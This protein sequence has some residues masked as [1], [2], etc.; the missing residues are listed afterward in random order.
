MSLPESALPANPSDTFET[1]AAW[2]SVDT[3]TLPGNVPLG[4]LSV[5]DSSVDADALTEGAGRPSTPTPTPEAGAYVLHRLIARG[6]FGEVWEAT[7]ASIGRIVAVKRLRAEVVNRGGSTEV[8]FRQE[9]LTA[10]QLEHPNIVPVHDLGADS[11]GRPV[12]AMKMVRGRTWA[13]QIEEDFPRLPVAE[14]LGAHLPI[15]M[16]TAQA[17]AFAHSRGVVHRDLKP[18]QVMTGEFGE[19][20][21]MDWGLAMAFGEGRQ[22]TDFARVIPGR[23]SAS[24]P[25]GTPVFMAPE[26][27]RNDASGVGPWT[28]VFLLGGIL[29]LLL[30]G[31]PP[32]DAPTSIMAMKL[33]E[34][35]AVES[36]AKRAKGRE[37]PSELERICLKALAKEPSQRHESAGALLVALRDYISGASRRRQAEELARTASQRLDEAASSYLV[38][39]EAISLAAQARALW[40]E[41]PSARGAEERGLAL[42]AEAALRKGDLGLA[43]VQSERLPET[44]ERASLAARIDSAEA[45]LRRQGA[46]RRAA[47]AAAIAML[48]LLVAGTL[49]YNT[50]LS[51][52]RDRA[53]AAR[54]SAESARESEAAARAKERLARAD[55]EQLARFM[56]GDL[57]EKLAPRDPKLELLDAAATEALSYYTGQT[58]DTLGPEELLTYAQGAYTLADLLRTQGRLDDAETAAFAAEA[59]AGAAAASPQ[60]RVDATR[61]R[62]ILSGIFLQIHFARG[63][64]DLA[65]QTAAE[66]SARLEVLRAEGVREVG[67]LNDLLASKSW[68][69]ALSRDLAPPEEVLAKWDAY[70]EVLAD[71]RDLGMPDVRYLP[72]LGALAQ[73]RARLQEDLGQIELADKTYREALEVLE[74]AY[75]AA[76]PPDRDTARFL[77]T[78]CYRYGRF[79]IRREDT[80]AA[81]PVLR[82]AHEVYL[83]LAEASPDNFEL[84]KELGVA[85]EGLVTLHD[86]L[87]EHA[88]A[89]ARL[90]EQIALL[91]RLLERSPDNL[92]W[93]RERIAASI[94]L[95]RTVSKLGDIA[96]ALAIRKDAQELLRAKIVD[97]PADPPLRELAASLANEA[98]AIALRMGRADE[99]RAAFS[100]AIEHYR[101]IPEE[102]RPLKNVFQEANLLM[103]LASG[104]EIDGDDEP[105]PALFAEARALYERVQREGPQLDPG[106]ANL[107][108]CLFAGAESNLRLGRFDAARDHSDAA[109][110]IV[111][112]AL[113]AAPDDAAQ[114]RRCGQQLVLRGRIEAAA[115]GDAAPFL[116]EGLALLEPLAEGSG[117][118]PMVLQAVAW[119]RL[120]SGDLEGAREAFGRMPAALRKPPLSERLA[121]P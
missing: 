88:E 109:L 28:D 26:Q 8:E 89:K 61:T 32:H 98:G 113:A 112:P 13:A 48:A 69:A 44:P 5:L 100:E 91:D 103:N 77:G 96:G 37:V 14:F 52:Q 17:V 83:P 54:L 66:D 93:F 59:A 120:E 81:G 22:S 111:R 47:T 41:C 18:S 10:A 119:G 63:R 42:Y 72:A 40:A 29:Y 68:E 49:F 50:R 51:E 45:S 106:G 53:E 4:L 70:A 121:E 35:G 33:A 118:D 12:I 84:Q 117:A 55:A 76:D 36:P 65:L 60:H 78:T 3:P 20:L 114:Q 95:S 101:A 7:Q 27:T 94:S 90:V 104:Y 38:L 82:R 24:S 67:M 56:L 16:A 108:R 92:P 30:T 43:R 79:L 58:T 116:R 71:M 46:Q 57:R 25:A 9:A 99:V 87:G 21:L 115:G 19:V 23:E 2:N 1:H 107:T 62:S 110:A 75:A 102:G 80:A 11:A 6:G 105:L 73:N 64:R 97:F 86:A 31:R 85:I 74:G 39:G 15:L 34:D